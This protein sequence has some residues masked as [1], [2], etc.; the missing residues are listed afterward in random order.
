MRD[1]A[2][3]HRAL[4]KGQVDAALAACR[5]LPAVE[6]TTVSSDAGFIAFL[7]ADPT[8][9]QAAASSLSL[10]GARWSGPWPAFSFAARWLV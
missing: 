4:T 10:E 9:F 2:S 3:R 1:V 8:A 5:H 6:D 7:V